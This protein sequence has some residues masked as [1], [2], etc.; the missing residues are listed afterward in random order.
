ML[1]GLSHEGLKNPNETALLF[2]IE[3]SMEKKTL[4]ETGKNST[5]VFPQ[6][7][8]GKGLHKFRMREVHLKVREEC[9]AV[10]FRSNS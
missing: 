2:C 4:E 10:V 9:V 5:G 7:E 3:C 8:T 6:L 1:K